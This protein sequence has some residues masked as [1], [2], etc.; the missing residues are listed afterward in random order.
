MVNL[1]IDDYTLSSALPDTL[2]I[3]QVQNAVTV[4][5]TIEAQTIYSTT[6]F[7]DNGTCTFYELRQIVEQNMTA[8]GLTLAEFSLEVNYG[9]NSDIIDDKYIVFSRYRNINDNH[10]D[11]LQSQFLINRSYY[12]VPRNQTAKIPFFATP[13]EN[14]SVYYDCLMLKDGNVN[15]TRVTINMTHYNQPH[16]YYLS[17]SPATIKAKVNAL[18]GTDGGKL[19]SFTPHVGN[20]SIPV[21]VIDETP[22]ALFKFRNTYNATESIFIFGTS[23]TK[24][25]IAQ[26][27]A[28]TMD[29]A[30][31]YDKTITRK[32][33]IKTIPL[34]IEEANWYNE[35]L[36]ADYV[37]TDMQG[38]QT[39]RPVLISDTS[40]EISNSPKD[41]IHIKFSWRYN[42]NA[43]WV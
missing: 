12:T 20:R 11:F 37:T 33:E 41:S 23:T 28:T 2:S 6:L 1:F 40:S 26:K 3:T 42:D 32:H 30:S 5:I 31:F 21:F 19:L 16:I 13:T 34:T 24:T 27:E 7:P 4:E 10:L 18:L 14:F 22:C 29:I 38:D 43:R 25:E 17:V 15:T 8:R 35:F 9:G 36:E 39:D